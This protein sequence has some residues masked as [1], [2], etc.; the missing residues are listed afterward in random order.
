MRAK[1]FVIENNI[2]DSTLPSSDEQLSGTIA[3]AL[4]A[5]YSIPKLPNSD[6]Y[7]QYRFGVAIAGARSAK[8]R[9]DEPQSSM[10]PASI[11]GESEI[12]IAYGMDPNVIDDALKTIGLTPSDKKLI[13]TEKSEEAT[14][15]DTKSPVSSF[16][17]YGK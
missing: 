14:D 3:R 16:R 17:G 5:T 12:V 4:P 1:E 11:W 8:Q 9:K 2:Q 7:K 13:S 10:A 6:F 15:I